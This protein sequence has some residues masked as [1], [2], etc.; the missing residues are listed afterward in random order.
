MNARLTQIVKAIEALGD[1]PLE[2]K[3]RAK[4]KHDGIVQDIKKFIK[5]PAENTEYWKP[6]TCY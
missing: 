2:A 6:P 3:N 4:K 1:P 5:Q